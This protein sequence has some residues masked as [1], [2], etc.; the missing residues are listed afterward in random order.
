MATR[1]CQIWRNWLSACRK[2]LAMR[3]LRLKVVMRLLPP[4]LKKMLFFPRLRDMR[5]SMNLP[6]K[7]RRLLGR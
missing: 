1:I 2:Y 5:G 3:G 6:E 4:E 7:D